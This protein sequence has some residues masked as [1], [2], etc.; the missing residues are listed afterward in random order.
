MLNAVIHR[1]LQ[2]QFGLR[3]KTGEPM[4]KHTSWR[5]GGPAEFFVE[6][7]NTLEL[8]AVISL[9]KRRG[10]PL[11][12][13][14]NGTNLL[15]GEK[16]ISG[17]VLKI[18][19]KMSRVSILGKD[20]LAEAGTRLSMLAT[21][22][23]DNNLGGLEFAAGIPGTV[24]GAV[25]MN[26]GA[27][28]A[29]IGELVKEVLL[30]DKEG[31][32]CRRYGTDLNFNYRSTALQRESAIVVEVKFSCF[33]REKHLIQSDMNSFIARRLATQPQ[34]QPNAGSVF[35]NPPGDSAGRLIEA[36]GLK[37]LRIGDAQ[38]S[39][40][41]ANFIVNLGAATSADV[42]SLIEKIKETVYNRFGVELLLEVQVVGD[43]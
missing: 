19:P 4:C 42:L 25:I 31:H 16:G 5:I 14:G 29:S 2:E 36:A 43:A 12:V 21:I 33:A 9:A 15:V 32:L 38:V 22:A 6:P 30:L 10:L 26:A 8:Q 35:K 40:K 13:I 28:G 27:N 20:I 39:D 7:E 41:H 3:L 37:S 18:G 23:R 1:E 17:I 34:G 24:G 11:T